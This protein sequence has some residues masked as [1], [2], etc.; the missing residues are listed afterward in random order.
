MRSLFFLVSL[1][2]ACS[3]TFNCPTGTPTNGDKCTDRGFVCES[4]GGDHER[5]S[6]IST[7]LNAGAATWSNAS[8]SMCTMTNDAQCGATYTSTNVGDTCPTS[9]LSCDYPEGRCSCQPCSTGTS[10]GLSWQCRAWSDGLA[11]NCPSE[12]PAIGSPCTTPTLVCRYFSTASSCVSFGPDIE[13]LNERWQPN[14]GAPV[15]CAE[16]TCGL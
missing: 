9:G 16:P 2:G 7:C 11:T 5:C 10:M 1:L 6:T 8:D 15:A 3:N 12:R 13:C 14:T 4:G